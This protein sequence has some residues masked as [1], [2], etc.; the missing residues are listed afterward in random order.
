LDRIGE[1][2]EPWFIFSLLWSVG[3]TVDNNGRKK[4]DAFLREKM[5]EHSV[6]V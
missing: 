3:G 4:F 6:G 5:K 1:L 2:I